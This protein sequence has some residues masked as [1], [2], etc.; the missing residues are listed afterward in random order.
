MHRDRLLRGR[1]LMD[2][3][4]TRLGEATLVGRCTLRGVVWVIAAGVE[5][6]FAGAVGLEAGRVC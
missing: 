5:W 4:G 3:A 2:M 1:C 6:R